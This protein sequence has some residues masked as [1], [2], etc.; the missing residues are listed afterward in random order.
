MFNPLAEFFVVYLK[1]TTLN[2]ITFVSYN[3]EPTLVHFQIEGILKLPYVC[4]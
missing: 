1:I 3:F 2:S 4:R